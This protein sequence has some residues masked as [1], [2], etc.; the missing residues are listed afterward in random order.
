MYKL[1][2]PTVVIFS[3]ASNPRQFQFALWYLKWQV[4]LYII[5]KRF[6]VK[7]TLHY[8]RLIECY[9]LSTILNDLV[10]LLHPIF[11]ELDLAVS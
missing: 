10:A 11:I 3:H 1:K 5:Y 2:I 6:F 4:H 9:G 8:R 7:V